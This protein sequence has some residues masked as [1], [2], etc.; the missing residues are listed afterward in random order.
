MTEVA[1]AGQMDLPATLDGMSN[2][3]IRKL[4]GQTYNGPKGLPQLTINHFA[5]DEFGV[6]LPRGEWQVYVEDAEGY[7]FAEEVQFRPFTRTFH[8]SVWDNEEGNYSS[9]SVEQT[10]FNGPFEDTTGTFKCGRLSAKEL[11]NLDPNSPEAVVSKNV[12]CTQLVYGWV[13]FEGKDAEGNSYNVENLPCTWRARGAS[14]SA[15]DDVLKELTKRK[16]NWQYVVLKLESVRKKKG[17]NTFFAASAVVSTE[18]DHLGED[19]NQIMWD[20]M[21]TIEGRNGYILDK[22]KEARGGL[23]GGEFVDASLEAQFDERGGDDDE[24]PF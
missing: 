18:I 9:R 5:E 13:S 22:H 2:E 3:D 6:K 14:Y 23:S 17:G 7:V 4:A 1:V 20:F 19:D 21:K 11:D 8:Y 16:A 24:V 10:S 15:A 12:K